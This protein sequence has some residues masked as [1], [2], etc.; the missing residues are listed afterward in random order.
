MPQK[1]PAR[2]G[3]IVCTRCQCPLDAVSP[4]AGDWLALRFCDCERASYVRSAAPWIETI[5]DDP[6]N[7]FSPVRH[8]SRQRAAALA[9]LIG[10]LGP[11][12]HDEDERRIAPRIRVALPIVVAPLDEHFRPSGE[13]QNGATID[14]STSGMLF[15][16]PSVPH[17]SFWLVDFGP[18]GHPGSQTVVRP[19]RCRRLDPN[20]WEVAGPFASVL[21]ESARKPPTIIRSSRRH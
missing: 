4:V 19:I 20:C 2:T 5:A 1:N 9:E 21:D 3:A 17:S 11:E 16:T 12:S 13:A 14:I 8:L 15:V 18:V 6:Y 7:R 10:E